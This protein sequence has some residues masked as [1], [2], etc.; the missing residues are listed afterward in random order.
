MILLHL[1]DI[2]G[3]LLPFLQSCR[4]KF[5]ILILTGDLFPNIKGSQYIKAED[6]FEEEKEY[7]KKFYE[8]N[9]NRI[10]DVLKDRK[11]LYTLGNHDFIGFKDL[12]YNNCIEMNNE[13][14]S[15][16]INGYSFWGFCQVNEFTNYHWNNETDQEKLN[17]IVEIR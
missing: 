3:D 8:Y 4:R 16:N 2:H 1:G 14:N 9:K 17:N 15:I 10:L 6:K 11:I 12:G 13:N 5:D 7:Q